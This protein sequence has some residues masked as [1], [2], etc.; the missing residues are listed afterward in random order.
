MLDSSIVLSYRTTMSGI[1]TIPPIHD[2]VD[3]MLAVFTHSSLHDGDEP[4][5]E[6]YGDTLRLRDLGR[7]VLE[8]AVT[9]HL[10]S[11]RPMLR[12]EEIEVSVSTL[13]ANQFII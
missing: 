12:E 10:F 3:L 5:K 13:A 9:Y 2:D 1:P 8:L 11:E 4:L 6:P 7:R